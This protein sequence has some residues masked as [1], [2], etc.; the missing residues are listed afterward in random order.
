M[1]KNDGESASDWKVFVYL[2]LENSNGHY[3]NERYDCKTSKNEIMKFYDRNKE[4]ALLAD[5]YE[6]SQQEAQNSAFLLV[7]RKYVR[8]AQERCILCR[9]IMGRRKDAPLLPIIHHRIHCRSFL[10]ISETSLG[11]CL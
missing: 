1:I 4:L 11:S 7:V 3:G 5:I 9:P 2:Q 8:Q 6:R 10:T